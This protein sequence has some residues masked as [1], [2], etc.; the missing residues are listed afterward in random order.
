MASVAEVRKSYIAEID[1]VEMGTIKRDRPWRSAGG[2]KNLVTM[3]YHGLP[4]VTM[5][6]REIEQ[7]SAAAAPVRRKE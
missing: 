1:R 5:S 3:G 6:G 4:Q 2:E 7:P